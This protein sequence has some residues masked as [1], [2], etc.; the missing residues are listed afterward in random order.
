M[1]PTATLPDVRA[2]VRIVNDI[3][4]KTVTLESTR[5]RSL[6]VFDLMR[7]VTQLNR[8]RNEVLKASLHLLPDLI[9]IHYHCPET[10]DGLATAILELT[11]PMR[12]IESLIW[13][14]GQ[15]A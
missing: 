8:L 6:V 3:T 15:H 1:T 11:E 14:G 10:D 12:R 5:D 13:K 9:V 7:T 4:G 2:R